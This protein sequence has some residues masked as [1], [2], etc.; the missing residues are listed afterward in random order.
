MYGTKNE[1]ER[2]LFIEWQV[3]YHLLGLGW[4]KQVKTKRE[5]YRVKPINS[6]CQDK[7]FELYPQSNNDLNI[8]AMLGVEREPNLGDLTRWVDKT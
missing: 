8:V 5:M 4:K 7:E 3:V 1:K 6:S 2:Y